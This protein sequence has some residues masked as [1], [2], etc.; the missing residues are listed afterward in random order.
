MSVTRWGSALFT[1]ALLST[2]AVL[3]PIAQAADQ[4]DPALDQQVDGAEDTAADQAVI[5]SGHVDVGPRFIDGTWQLQA[6]D[7]R[8]VPA[9]WRDVADTVLHVNDA[10]IL[11]VPDSADYAFLDQPAGKEVW[12][13]PQ[14][15]SPQVVWVGWNTQDP[16]VAGRLDLGASLTLHGVQG[17]GETFVFLQE[18]VAGAPNL[19]WNST[20]AL[21]QDLWMENN[22]HVHANWVFTEPGVYLMDVEVHADLAD[23]SHVSDRTV[24]R[25][26]VGDATD[27]Q[28]AFAA[29]LDQPTAAPSAP[30]STSAPADSGGLPTV[31]I[32]ALA[33]VGA[34]LLIVIA[35]GSI[36][37]ARR[38]RAIV[39][40]EFSSDEKR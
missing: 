12:V 20:E 21:P 23:G 34:A 27:G 37:V 2:G 33:G 25:F 18:G 16:E 3:A 7:D 40:A 39:E 10:A 19:L 4:P 6:R 14:V 22:T 36:M 38:R 35:G 9:V 17:P 30:V 29:S 24:L 13:V 1:I 8:A 11:P 28:A 26:A 31:V 15:Q 5:D 32:G